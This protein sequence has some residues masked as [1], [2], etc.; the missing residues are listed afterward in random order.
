MR[1]VRVTGTHDCVCLHA[2]SGTF[3]EVTED[4]CCISCGRSLNPI[5]VLEEV[6]EE[7]SL[8]NKFRELCSG[9]KHEYGGVLV[10]SYKA[11]PEQ[12][13]NIAMTHAVE[14]AKKAVDSKYCCS[15]CKNIL[16]ALK[17]EAELNKPN[18]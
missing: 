12:L 2:K 7:K 16:Y 14:V 13:V 3:L 1:K 5:Y 6:V 15:S 10:C 4:L 11:L 17:K 18:Q 8:E 9:C